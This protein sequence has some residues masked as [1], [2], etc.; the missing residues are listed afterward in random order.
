MPVKI[1][2]KHEKEIVALNTFEAK[3]LGSHDGYIK[4]KKRG[5][6]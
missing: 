4:I 6:M 5:K 1:S 3:I 2:Q